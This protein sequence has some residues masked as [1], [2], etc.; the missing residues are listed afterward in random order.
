MKGDDI[1]DRPHRP[2]V[3]VHV[4][5]DLEPVAV[6]LLEAL[7]PATN[8]DRPHVD[9]DAGDR[10]PAGWVQE[11]LDR[12][13]VPYHERDR[14]GVRWFLLDDCP[15]HPGEGA[16]DCGVGETVAGMALG[17]CFHNRG[18]GMMWA[19]FR[20]ALRL[21]PKAKGRKK[22][23]QADPPPD[24]SSC[25]RRRTRWPSPGSSSAATRAPRN[26]DPA[27]LAR[28]LVDVAADRTGSSARSARSG[29]RA[30]PS[31]RTPAT[32]TPRKGFEPWAADAVQDQEPA[33]GDGGHRPP[34]R[35]RPTSRRGSTSTACPSWRSATG[36][37]GS[38][39][40]PCCRTRR[41]TSTRPRSRSTT[42]PRRRA[43]AAWLAFLEELW[44]DDPE[45]IAALQEFFGYVIS[46]RLDLH[47]ILLIVG[48]TRGGKGT[49]ARILGKLIGPANV[50]GPTLS[51][52]SGDFGLAPLIGKPL[53]VISD[54]RLSR[55]ARFVGRRRAAARDQRRGHDHRQPQVPRP[56]DRQAALPVPRHQQR[57]APAR[58]RLRHDRQPVRRPAA[59]RSRGSGGRTTA[60]RIG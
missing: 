22:K 43:P 2:S 60:S 51:S 17:K 40:G 12:A 44:P 41:A 3:L 16:G 34:R 25:R 38:T 57:A 49:I 18:T 53:A 48:P 13:G 52:L 32:S 45:S 23:P 50:A 26:P 29:P 10:M 14:K 20:D 4:P 42:T 6:E 39:A 27:P 24:A 47:K 55:E 15:F 21:E 30:T 35:D 28:R 59:S 36:C 1:A 5:D 33:R 56:V 8:G 46:G 31:P 7:V 11:W 37:S 9:R 19:D 58:R 54:A